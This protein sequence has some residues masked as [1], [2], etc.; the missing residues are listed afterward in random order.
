[1]RLFRRICATALVASVTLLV[2]CGSDTPVA[3]DSNDP[4]LATNLDFT[5][6]NTTP[7][8]TAEGGAQANPRTM[9]VFIGGLIAAAS[10]PA[11]GTP[12]YSPSANRNW[13]TISTAPQF[14]RTPLGWYFDFTVDRTGLADGLYTATIPV[15]VVGARNNPQSIVVSFAVC[16]ATNCLFMGSNRAGSLTATN[17][18]NPNDPT[19]FTGSAAKWFQEWRLFLNP[20]QT[21]YIQI[22]AG[23]TGEG[24]LSDSYIYLWQLPGDAFLGSN[25]D[26]CGLD[27]ELPVTNASGSIVQYRVYASH[28]GGKRTGT[29][30]IVISPTSGWLGCGGGDLRLDATVAPGSWQEAYIAKHGHPY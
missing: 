8:F 10:Y 9:K 22:H 21:A 5:V 25:D 1:M 29:Y 4:S 12:V 19:P 17:D 14:S 20:G 27:S 15:T 26:F 11:L 28:F 13:L 2:A 6:S 23:S 30:N 18:F 7:N 16:A 24:T 3:T